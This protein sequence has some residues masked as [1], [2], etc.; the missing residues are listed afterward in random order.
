MKTVTS[1]APTIPGPVADTR[2]PKF[3]LPPEACDCHAHVF[4]PQS[5]YPYLPQAG[6]IPPDVTPFA[7]AVVATAPDRV[8]W[9]T[10]WPHPSAH[11][12]APNDGTLADLL[13]DWIPDETRRNQVLVGN[14]VRLYG[15]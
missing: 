6:Y 12:L 15:F 7:R 4:G 14:P 9:G 11:G 8:V 2:P 13:L 5:R 10:D 1:R 3:K